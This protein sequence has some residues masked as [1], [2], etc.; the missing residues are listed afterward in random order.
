MIE[1]F[2]GPKDGDEVLEPYASRP[3][4]TEILTLGHSRIL[5]L[6]PNT[7]DQPI[8]WHRYVRIADGYEYRGTM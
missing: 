2:G 3:L 1:F 7:P 4:G 5:A 8:T 6:E